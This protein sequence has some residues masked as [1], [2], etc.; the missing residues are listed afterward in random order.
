MGTPAYVYH[1]DAIRSRYR[2][3]DV[4]YKVNK[5]SGTMKLKG[6]Y[7]GGVARF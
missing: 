4:L 2:S 3:L 5:D 6:L 1:A 7:F